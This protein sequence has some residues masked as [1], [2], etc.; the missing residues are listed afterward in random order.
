MLPPW[1]MPPANTV[2][3]REIKWKNGSPAESYGYR[4]VPE[5]RQERRHSQY[6]RWHRN[7]QLQLQG[8]YQNGCQVGPWIGWHENGNKLWE[9]PYDQQ[10]RKDGWEVRYDENGSGAIIKKIWW[11]NGQGGDDSEKPSAYGDRQ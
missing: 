11:K 2:F 6:R 4:L 3:Q 8:E 10:G 5:S 9:I 1:Q 7:G